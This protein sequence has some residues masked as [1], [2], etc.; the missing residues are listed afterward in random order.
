MLEANKAVV[1]RW[2]DEVWN[3][4]RSEAI[5]EMFAEDGIVH[6]LADD[7]GEAISGF[8]GFK[9]FHEIFRRAFPDLNIRV[10]HLIAEG[11]YVVAHCSAS[12]CHSGDGLGIASKKSFEI[13]GIS[14]SRMED[15][16]IAEAWNN[17]DFLTLYRQIGLL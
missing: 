17:F 1:Q 9:R 13:S 3:Q 7:K 14:I 10:E 8:E 4:G 15:G 6:G 11:D 16:K 2:Y 5:A 12:G